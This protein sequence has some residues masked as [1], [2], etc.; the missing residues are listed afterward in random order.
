MFP[1]PFWLKCL[2]G[3]SSLHR[4]CNCT[5][6]SWDDSGWRDEGGGSWTATGSGWHA[7]DWEVATG[8]GD[9]HQGHFK[10]TTNS[11]ETGNGY[12]PKANDP[13]GWAKGENR[14]SVRD[15][16]TVLEFGPACS[17]KVRLQFKAY[18]QR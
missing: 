15:Y 2:P 5:A 14:P 17:K 13:D 9:R 1:Q 12:R 18:T 16:E 6:M 10:R 4:Q 11:H 7:S 3:S 8:S